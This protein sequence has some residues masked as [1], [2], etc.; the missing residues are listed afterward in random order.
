MKTPDLEHIRKEI[1]SLSNIEPLFQGG[2]KVVYKATHEAYGPSVL[3]IILDPSATE[4]TQR[5]IDVLARCNLPNVPKLYEWG[6]F[7]WDTFQTTY[8]L[9]EYISGETLRSYLNVH[10]KLPLVGCLR[11]LKCLLEIAVE[12]EKLQLVH[13]DIKPE[14]I[15][16]KKDDGSFWLLDF[17]IARHLAKASITATNAHFGPHTAG[18]AAPE[19]FRNLKKE[20]DIRA[21]LF[22]IGVLVYEALNGEHPFV[23]GARDY[24]D[25]LRRTE[26]LP[27]K[28]LLIPGDS[29]RQLGGFINIMMDKYASRRPRTA[30]IALDWYVALLPSIKM[31]EM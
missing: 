27:T 6:P 20:I 15:I 30:Q 23:S 10:K 8:L 4:R 19:Q 21:D 29:Q 2:Q 14:N 24:L 5:E 31:E 3:K 12:L 7:I 9:E 1:H 13:R 11:L 18:Y 28:V 22:S 16:I 17:G 26:S 25:I